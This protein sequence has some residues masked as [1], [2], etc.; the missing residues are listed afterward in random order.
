MKKK[1]MFF[2]KKHL[3]K[4]QVIAVFFHPRV[5]FQKIFFFNLKQNMFFLI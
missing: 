1:T 3:W 4:K 5:F 2:E